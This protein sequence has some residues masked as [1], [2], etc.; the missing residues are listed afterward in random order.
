MKI[1]STLSYSILLLVSL[2]I[3]T[4]KTFAQSPSWIWA[5]SMGSTNN[6]DYGFSVSTDNIGDSYYTGTFSG[7]VDFDPGPGVFNLT[8]PPLWSCFISKLD[9]YGNLVWAYSVDTAQGSKITLDAAGNVYITGWFYGTSDF[10]PGP[11]IYNLTSGA[12]ASIFITKVDN[13]GNF[14]WAKRICG[15]SG[16]DAS[17]GIAIDTGSN[18]AVFITGEFDQTEDFDPDTG[19]YNLTPAGNEDI[20]ICKLDGSGNFVWARKIGGISQ[21]CIGW[22]IAID[23]SGSGGIYSTGE[24][25]GTVDFDPGPGVYNLTGGGAFISKIDSSG[26]FVWAKKVNGS[27]GYGIGIEPSGTNTVYITGEFYGTVD[28]NPDSVAVFNM[29]SAG[30][31]DAFIL[32][33]SP[34]GDFIWANEMGGSGG[35]DAGK[36]IFID[37][38]GNVYSTGTFGGLADFDPGAGSYN[39]GSNGLRDIYVSKLDS[40]GS[41]QWAKRI[42][43]TQE[44]FAMG[45]ALDPLNN[46]LLTGYYRSPNMAVGSTTLTNSGGTTWESDIFMAKLDHLLTGIESVTYSNEISI[47]P[48][49]VTDKLTILNNKKSQIDRIEIYDVLGKKLIQNGFSEKNDGYVIDV[50]QLSSGLYSVIIYTEK[51]R[52]AMKLLKL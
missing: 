38:S 12:A 16:N 1:I 22:D 45:L 31:F 11:G 44:D 4:D 32:K 8:S 18:E 3:K 30:S 26:N 35:L 47:I 15:A 7:T 28:F 49:P 19:V 33:L 9:S 48:N 52:S 20:F 43:G 5:K 34:T 10:D 42:G 37:Y 51:A 6:M 17:Y 27:Y 39:I 46:V 41:F 40:S 14:I 21:D 13:G 50:S 36:D 29:A 25:S 24:F 2:F 23:P